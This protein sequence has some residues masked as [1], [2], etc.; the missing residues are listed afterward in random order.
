MLKLNLNRNEASTKMSKKH[1]KLM[2]AP[3][4]KAEADRRLRPV[5]DALYSRNSKQALKLIQQALLKRPG[6]PAARALRACVLLQAERRKE[7]ES[8]ITSLRSDLDS[9]RVPIDE[10][11][12]RKLFLYFR[13][14]RAEHLAGGIYEQAWSA[15]M[16][17]VHLAETAFC[18]YMRGYAFQEAQKLATKLHRFASAKTQKYGLWAT[19]A[20][21]ISLLYETRNT[22]GAAAPDQ[23]MLRLAS[24]M[25]RKALAVT[26][27]PS[28]ETVRFAVRVYA[29]AGEMQNARELVSHPRLVMDEAEVLH[30]RSE[31]SVDA[32][33]GVRDCCEVLLKHDPDDWVHWLK[34]FHAMEK[35]EAWKTEAKA[36]IDKVHSS[37][38]GTPALKRGPFLAFIELLY[39]D[40]NIEG[41]ASAVQ[42]YFVRFGAKTVC[43]HDLRPYLCF[44]VGTPFF[45][46]TI[47]ELSKVATQRGFPYHMTVS[48]L[49]LWFS[50]LEES[51]EALVSRYL[52][53]LSDSLE[54]TDRQPGD[55][56]IIMAVHKLLPVANAKSC[57]RYN[58]GAAVFEAVVILE[59]GL[60][61]SPHNFHFKLLLIRL[62]V[63][64]GALERVAELWESLDVKHIQLATLTHLVLRPF[65]EMGHHDALRN[66]LD[67]AES[68]WREC[69]R[70][71]PE[72]VSKAFQVGSINAAIEFLLFKT[73]LEKSSVLVRSFITESQL[74]LANTNGNSLGIQRALNCLVLSPRF[75]EETLLSN[76]VINNDDSRCFEFWDIGEYGPNSRLTDL[77]ANDE[78]GVPLSPAEKAVL[79]ADLSSQKSL[80][81]TAIRANHDEGQEYPDIITRRGSNG[82]SGSF[83]DLP[84][85]CKL[86]LDISENIRTLR[87]A[88]QFYAHGSKTDER[89]QGLSSCQLLLNDSKDIM[90]RL[91]SSVQDAVESETGTDVEALTMSPRK[92]R[93]CGRIAYDILLVTSV[94]LCSFSA[95]ILKGRRRIKK[96]EPQK[97]ND[98]ESARQAILGYRDGLLSACVVFQEWVMTCLENET[99]WVEAILPGEDALSNLVT[100]FP[101]VVHPVDI[102]GGWEKD[103]DSLSRS[104]FCA[105]IVNKTLASHSK[106]CTALLE[107]LSSITRRLKLVDL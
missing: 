7:A 87:Q 96:S 32:D 30:I 65:F 1:T 99:D 47:D 89:Q 35:R 22:E 42:D 4:P 44:L 62:Y 31:L 9:G 66:L 37:L 12:A 21:W 18:M 69:D 54:T 55:D 2:S 61:R 23:R 101:N 97:A 16:S 56:Y 8:E 48:W 34:F 86:R 15:N 103:N 36:F 19:A 45:E 94:A 79:Q 82:M 73:R 41:L 59:T 50:K 46:N 92:L 88:L 51:P 33:D 52:S 14:T 83:S 5:M 68:L 106:T 60:C 93:A 67:G 27:I 17:D 74:E 39:R 80:L 43:A 28:A 57:K 13:E 11:A 70:E 75:T 77:N 84:P 29:E 6:W 72:C 95:D 24:A 100:Y 40:R 90:N 105:E 53:E 49:R 107:T 76:K 98:F 104:E 81:E 20:L 3:V 58:N 10:D 63:E 26:S 25:M 91:A 78:E 38:E 85:L 102:Q 64:I 71:I